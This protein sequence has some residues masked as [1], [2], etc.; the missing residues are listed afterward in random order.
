M[1]PAFAVGERAPS[2]G[3][4]ESGREARASLG[5]LRV[6]GEQG[7]HREIESASSEVVSQYLGPVPLSWGAWGRRCIIEVL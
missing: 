4:W 7:E 3:S 2:F 1:G 6:V 5:G